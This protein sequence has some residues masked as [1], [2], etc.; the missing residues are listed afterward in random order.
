MANIYYLSK[1]YKPAISII[2]ETKEKIGRISGDHSNENEMLDLY[3]ANLYRKIF[4][5]AEATEIYKR[6]QC[7]FEDRLYYADCINALGYSS[8]AMDIL[9]SSSKDELEKLDEK[10]IILKI[11]NSN[12]SYKECIELSQTLLDN[13]TIDLNE[14]VVVMA[15]KALSLIKTSQRL[16]ALNIIHELKEALKDDEMDL[17]D[18]AVIYQALSSVMISLDNHDEADILLSEFEKFLE[19]FKPEWTIGYQQEYERLRTLL[20]S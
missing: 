8:E 4:R 19:E 16:E 13:Y 1:L 17:H 6:Y 18:K 2:D 10:S 3:H 15:Q 14:T 7:D 12:K 20:L 11:F 9:K 5:Y